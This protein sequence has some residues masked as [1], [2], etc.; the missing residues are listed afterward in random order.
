MLSFLRLIPDG[1]IAWVQED[2]L[3]VI[4][5]MMTHIVPYGPE[6]V[7]RDAGASGV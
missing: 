1:M 3:I 7:D 5:S 4:E 6:K 2:L